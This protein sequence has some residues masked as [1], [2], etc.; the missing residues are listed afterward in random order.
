[1]CCGHF[2]FSNVRQLSPPTPA[3]SHPHHQHQ[4]LTQATKPSC[5]NQRF[6]S[7]NHLVPYFSLSLHLVNMA[8]KSDNAENGAAP[9][10]PKAGGG[11]STLTPRE[12]EI[13]AK[14]MTCLKTAPEVSIRTQTICTDYNHSPPITWPR[15]SCSI[16]PA[17][18]ND[19]CCKYRDC[20]RGCDSPCR[21]Y[22]CVSF[23]CLETP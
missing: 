13:L 5:S 21:Q 9:A 2:C 16:R 10:T 1:M 6:C 19:A 4:A 12:Q 17:T 11:Y 8:G 15:S 22:H 14:A 20:R 3:A 23:Q 18:D 7:S